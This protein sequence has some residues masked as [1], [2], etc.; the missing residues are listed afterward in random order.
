MRIEQARRSIMDAVLK[1]MRDRDGC[2]VL[3]NLEVRAI[4]KHAVLAS[5]KQP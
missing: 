5:K 1:S 4:N 2:F 3:L